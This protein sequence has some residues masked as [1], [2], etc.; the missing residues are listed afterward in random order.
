MTKNLFGKDE[1]FIYALCKKCELFILFQHT[2]GKMLV[3]ALLLHLCQKLNFLELY[4]FCG[5]KY[6][7]MHFTVLTA[8]DF[9][10]KK[11]VCK[12]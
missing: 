10:L 6:F 2:L 11:V 4:T 3:T 7:L 8:R 12:V 1:K 9:S 5:L